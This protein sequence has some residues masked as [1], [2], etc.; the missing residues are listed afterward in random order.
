M[1]RKLKPETDFNFYNNFVV[2][3]KKGLVSEWKYPIAK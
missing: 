2:G 1:L 3:E